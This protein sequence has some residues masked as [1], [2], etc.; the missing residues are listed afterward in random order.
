MLMQIL[1]GSGLTIVSTMIAAV[2]FGGISYVMGRLQ[3]WL[4]R[5]PHT[6]KQMLML[7]FGLVGAMLM[8]TASVW[9]W[10]AAYRWLGIFETLEESLYFSLV[11]FTTLG[12][13]DIV[14]PQEWRLLSGLIAAN[15]ILNVGVTSAMIMNLLR[16]MRQDQAG[17]RLF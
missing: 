4:S 15:G 6:G 11:A 17:P 3:G 1:I 14:L 10:A 13:G 16:E 8:I 5:P 9:V 2:V 7:A 12:F